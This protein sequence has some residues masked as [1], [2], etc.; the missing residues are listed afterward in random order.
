M[1]YAGAKGGIGASMKTVAKEVLDQL[2]PGRV[3]R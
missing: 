1:G 3:R 2:K